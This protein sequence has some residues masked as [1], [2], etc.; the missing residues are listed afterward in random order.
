MTIAQ[1]T[2]KAAARRLA[3]GAIRNGFIFEALHAYTDNRGRPQ[4]YRIRLKNPDTGDKW[5]RPMKMNGEGYE[6]AEPK[7]TGGKPLY[8]LFHF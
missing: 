2:P 7:F 8:G 3:R 6:L 4:F 1:E 5:I